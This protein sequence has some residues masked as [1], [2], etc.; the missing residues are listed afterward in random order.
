MARRCKTCIAPERA[1]VEVALRRGVP[2]REIG[3]RHGLGASSLHRHLHGHMLPPRTRWQSTFCIHPAFSPWRGI[4]SIIRSNSICRSWC[5]QDSEELINPY[6]RSRGR[7]ACA[8]VSPCL[9][10]SRGEVVNRDE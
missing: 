10:Q 7:S 5:S 9:Y 6:S 1:E 3:E 2:L 8:K 4:D